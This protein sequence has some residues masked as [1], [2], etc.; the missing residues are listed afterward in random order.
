L[1]IQLLNKMPR[2][3][4]S[5]AKSN[6]NSESEL[7]KANAAGRAMNDITGGL[8]NM[9]ADILN[10]DD[11]DLSKF[12]ENG[13]GDNK[14]RASMYK[15][16]MAEGHKKG[17]TD[18]KLIE[19]SFEKSLSG[20][21][22]EE[23]YGDGDQK[24]LRRGKAQ[25]LRTHWA[26]G[27]DYSPL[28]NFHLSDW[29]RDCYNGHI[30][31]V[32]ARLAD[33]ASV[34]KWLDYRESSLRFNGI[35]HI[36]NG[37]R[38]LAFTGFMSSYKG[39]SKG[40]HMECLKFL[41]SK[42]ANPNC[43]DVAGYTPIHHCTLHRYTALTLKM[44]E[45]LVKHGADVNLTNRFGDN[46]LSEPVMHRQMDPIHFLMKNGISV[47]A[48]SYDGGIT[49]YKTAHYFPE[50]KHVL[51]TYLE[52]RNR[53]LR[54]KSNLE[55]KYRSCSVCQKQCSQRCQGCYE[56]WYCDA[57][58][59]KEAWK[60]HKEDCKQIRAEYKTAKFTTKNEVEITYNTNQA[61]AYKQKFNPKKTQFIVKVQIPG[62]LNDMSSKRE[63]YQYLEAGG[64]LVY[65]SDRSIMGY[66]I[67]SENRELQAALIDTI[68]KHGN[69]K[70][71]K[72]YFLA[73]MTKDGLL[74]INPK[75]IQ[76]PQTW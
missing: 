52:E 21:M 36:I 57:K 71:M 6:I 66:L 65:N 60:A 10:R 17:L 46:A 55:G 72:G 67:R 27:G 69:P 74:S 40:K 63:E 39:D 28:H 24:P 3:R 29:S 23:D 37:A 11:F 35:L 59:Q 62:Q 26:N 58:C 50:V 34:K 5:K 2:S 56:T 32:K 48:A 54:R 38:S 14:S 15:K 61:L 41:L 4:K 8:A 12:S 33:E 70:G 43:K 44:A 13:S 47:D 16:A 9:V 45:V 49:P 25:A 42:G 18:Q 22:S 19:E 31:K 53:E 68:N 75:R 76:L 7:K 73:I 30:E 64:L 51:N 1:R 20:K